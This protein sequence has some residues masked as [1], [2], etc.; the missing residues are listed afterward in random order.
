MTITEQVAKNI[1]KKLLKGEDYRIE[2]VTLI[3][4]E[5]LQFVVDFFKKVVDA[6]FKNQDIT[7]DWYKKEFLNSKLPTNDIAINSGLNKKTIHNMFNSSTREIVIDASDEHYDLLYESIKNLVD[8]EHDL[9]LTLTIKF[10]GVSVDL[11]VSESLIVIN[12]LAVKR[13]A[14]RGGSWSTAGKRVEKPLMQTLCK[15]Y[16]VSDKNYALKIKG[17]ELEEDEFER[18]I[19]FYLIEGKNQYKCEVKLMGIG[20]PESADAVIAR[21]S[22]VFVAD[23]LSNTNKNQLTSLNTEW[24]ELRSDG[25]FKRFENVL[26][27][28]KIPYTKLPSNV[29]KELEVVFKEIFR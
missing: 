12:T 17:K 23:K 29:D 10:K 18:E 4:A 3:D 1:I 8:T 6:K 26:K 21:A 16:G 22:K 14:I 7:I 9:E 20:N 24:V 28:L 5:F 15:L 27:N 2:I 11:N 13:A 19:D 25:G